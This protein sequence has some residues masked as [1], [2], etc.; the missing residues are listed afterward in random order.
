MN[1]GR[2]RTI[3]RVGLLFVLLMALLTIAPAIQVPVSAQ[4]PNPNGK[5]YLPLVV[6]GNEQ[7][8]LSVQSYDQPTLI[9]PFESGTEWK[10]IQGYYTTVSHCA[11]SSNCRYFLANGYQR[12]SLDLQVKGD[13]SAGDTTRGK[14]VLAPVSGTIVWNP[15]DG[16]NS[17][18]IRAGTT[19][20]GRY[21]CVLVC[22]QNLSIT[23]NP[24]GTGTW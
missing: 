7:E 1:A 17:V 21:Q 9:F 18:T 6:T 24:G 14:K 23:I 8:V 16:R 2:T 12:Y 13:N 5:I 20:N 11:V 19:S 3:G 22:H 10:I 15:E 4:E